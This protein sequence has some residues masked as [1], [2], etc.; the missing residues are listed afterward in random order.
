MQIVDTLMQVGLQ[1][2]E[3]VLSRGMKCCKGGLNHGSPLGRWQSR[4]EQKSNMSNYS[5]RNRY[6]PKLGTE[7]CMS[8]GGTERQ[9]AVEAEGRGLPHSSAPAGGGGGGL[10]QA[11]ETQCCMRF[12][13][14]TSSK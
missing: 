2:R 12:R 4:H 1:S 7:N 13:S 5:R 6:V 3:G 10:H 11:R 9:S 14:A 8:C